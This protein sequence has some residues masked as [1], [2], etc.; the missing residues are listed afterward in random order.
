[1]E[2]YEFRKKS[3]L[4]LNQLQ[5]LLNEGI[6]IGI[7]LQELLKK[8]DSIKRSLDD[9]IIRIV[10]LGS[11]SDGKTSAIAGLL[12]RFAGAEADGRR[13]GRFYD[14]DHPAAAVRLCRADADSVQL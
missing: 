7:D 11:F 12:G 8:V 1:M 5:K 13:A 9:G 2:Q 6:Q 3:N 4:R 14:G 10:L